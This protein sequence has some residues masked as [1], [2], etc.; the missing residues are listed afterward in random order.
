VSDIQ[1]RF[2]KSFNPDAKA[3]VAELVQ[4]VGGIDPTAL[5]FFCSPKYDL[6]AL[7]KAIDKT[8]DCPTIGCTTVGEILG[9]TGYIEDSIVCAALASDKLTMRPIFIDDLRAFAESANPPELKPLADLPRGKGFALFLIDGLS[10]MEEAV[11]AQIYHALKGAPLIGASAGGELDFSHTY[12]YYGGAFH[13]RAAVLAIVETSLPFA[14]LHIQ[15]FEPTDEKLVITEADTA[16]RVVTEINGLPACEEYARAVGVTI[17]KLTPQVFA[18][19]PVMLKIGDA[20]F[21]RSIQKL[22]PDGSLTFFCAIDVGLVLR[23]AKRAETLSENL[24]DELAKVEADIPHPALIFGSDC[25]QRRLE[26]QQRGEV[27]KANEVLAHYPF[28]GFSTF[29]EQFCGVH[30]NYTLTALVL[31]DTAT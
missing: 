28:I 6:A 25:V 1:V 26:I 8:F 14:A 16:N 10:M 19:H 22:N 12:V 4:Q 13:E 11:I 2:G 30:V 18:A 20:Y 3:A 23:V 9:E 7:G 17:D 29:G 31:G 24:A 5:I 27:E 15:H 21:V